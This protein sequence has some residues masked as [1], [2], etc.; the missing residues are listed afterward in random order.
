[1]LYSFKICHNNIELKTKCDQGYVPIEVLGIT[2]VLAFVHLYK[3]SL[4]CE[5]QHSTPYSK[6]E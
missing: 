1:M 5:L 3:P 4:F 6:P 2:P